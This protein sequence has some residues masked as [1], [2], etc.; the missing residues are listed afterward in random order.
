M[1]NTRVGIFSTGNSPAPGTLRA[2][3]TQSVCG[4]AQQVSSRPASS[5]ARLS[6]FNWCAP[7]STRPDNRRLLHDPQAP[8][9]QP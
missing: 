5:S 3:I 9:L 1:A 4:V 7:W 2:S 6:A 8:S